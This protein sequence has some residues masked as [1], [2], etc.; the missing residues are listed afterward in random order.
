MK[1]GNRHLP[2]TIVCILFLFSISL[3]AQAPVPSTWTLIEDDFEAGTLADW[4]KVPA[5]NPAAQPQLIAAEGVAGSTGLRVE[6]GTGESYL[7]QSDLMPADS[8]ALRFWFHPNSVTIPE[9]GD[10]IP[11]KSFRIADI[12]GGA[13]WD[14]IAAIRIRQSGGNYYGFLEWRDPQ[15]GTRYDYSGGEFSI[16]N[17]WQEITLEYEIDTALRVRI[18]D[19]LVREISNIQHSQPSATIVEVGK[20]SPNSTITPYG[21]ICYDLIS[22]Q[23]PSIPHLYVDQSEGNDQNDG[24]TPATAFASIQAAADIAGPGTV[25][26]IAAGFYNETVNPRYSGEANLPVVYQSETAVGDVVID[27]TDIDLNGW[28]GLFHIDEKEHIRLYGLAIQNS[29]WA[30]IMC[31]RC[32]HIDIFNCTTYDTR[33]SGIYI[34][35]AAYIKVKDNDIRKAVS[36]GTQEC[37][38]VSYCHDFELSYNKVHDGVGLAL[39]GEGIDVKNHCYSGSVHHN[40]VYDLPADYDPA[41]HEDGEVGIYIDG[42]SASPPEHL[43]NIHVYNNVVSTPVGIAVGAEQGGTVENVHVYNNIV[44]N[45]Y[46]TGINITNWVSPYTGVKK[47]IYILNNTIYGCGHFVESWPAG[48]GIY[49][50]S[51]VAEDENIVISNNVLSC[52]IGYQLKAQPD[53][54]DNLTAE[55]NLIDDLVGVDAYEIAGDFPLFGDPEFFDADNHI[56]SL[57]VTSAAIDAAGSA[58]APDFDYENRPRPLDGDRDGNAAIDVG[59]YEFDPSLF[60][61]IQIKVMLEGAYD[62]AG[63]NMQTGIDYGPLPN[64]SPYAADSRM[65]Q[66]IPENAVDW[67]LVGFT[68][69]SGDIVVKDTTLF[70]NGDGMIIDEHENAEIAMTGLPTGSY[71]LLLQHRNHLAVQSRFLLACEGGETTVYDFSSGREQYLSPAAGKELAA[72]VWGMVA[73][74]CNQDGSITSSDYV[75]WYNERTF[76]PVPYA[77]SDLNLDGKID[78]RD[79]AVWLINCRSARANRQIQ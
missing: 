4:G 59:A 39:G 10:W 73:G 53:A 70:L 8:G 33:S 45:C 58:H 42:Y 19:I 50:E 13:V 51:R 18:N 62:A 41:I 54:L 6:V 12:K 24:R 43:Y 60:P 15:V 66:N 34:S 35:N 28:G 61:F 40:H 44:Y 75:H 23:I 46:S 22:Y 48:G 21:F 1:F 11:S 52:N 30:G 27:G 20:A 55:F 77:V 67:V 31:T 56:F 65:V 25:V 7:Y 79:Y 47:H 74:D 68:T 2:T 3:Y 76:G 5:S 72:G 78:S 71:R 37:L 26:H 69:P 9:Q 49:L 36:G 16:S 29:T 14:V 38:S 32:E 57:L 63:G 64:Q 17:E